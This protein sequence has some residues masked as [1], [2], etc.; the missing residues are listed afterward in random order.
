MEV[1]LFPAFRCLAFLVVLCAVRRQH[2][3]SRIWCAFRML[4]LL[5]G[6]LDSEMATELFG[7]AGTVRWGTRRTARFLYEVFCVFQAFN[8]NHLFCYW[9]FWTYIERPISIEF[10]LSEL[11]TLFRQISLAAHRNA[12]QSRSKAEGLL[13]FCT[14]VLLL[15]VETL[16]A[17]QC[18]T[19]RARKK[20][21][22]HRK[23]L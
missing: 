3:F 6:W 15:L 9:I 18:Q 16:S 8:R 19:G 1:F 22:E 5:L 10:K 4:F 20:D 13:K 11:C 14:L 17:V 7:L 12:E 23:L 2:I 21:W